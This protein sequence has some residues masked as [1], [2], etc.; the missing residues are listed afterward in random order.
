M[1]PIRSSAAGLGSTV[2]AL[3]VASIAQAHGPAVS[4][5]RVVELQSPAS[6]VAHCQP[7]YAITRSIAT[8]NDFG[9]A[10]GTVTCYRNAVADPVSY[11]YVSRLV[12]GAPW[13]G[14]VELATSEP[15]QAFAYNITNRGEAF[16]YEIPASGGFF[17]TRWSLAG[18]RERL[19]FD[20]ACE[21]IQFSSAVDGNGRYTV[22][23]GLRGDPRLPP[24][25]DQLCISTRWLIRDPAGVET[26][27]PL[28]GSP[29]SLNAFNVAVGTSSQSAIRYNVATGDLVVLHAAEG[30][31]AAEA[32]HINDLGEVA[33]RLTTN[34]PG[35]VGNC[36]PGVAV[37]WD[38]KGLEQVLPH[39][40]G[41]VSS[42]AY[43][44]GYD[45]ET[46]GDSGAGDYC[47]AGDNSGERAVLWKDGR[48]HDLNSLIPKSERITLT[49]A[50]SINRRGQITAGGYANGEPLA[51]CALNVIDPET[52]LLTIEWGLC[53]NTRMYVLTPVG[54][55]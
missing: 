51:T 1:I 45:G 29:S 9:V 52:G 39:L 30:D 35:G 2:A 12:A 48:V 54:N 24:P 15:G 34:G 38:R 32:S 18:G 31:H 16:G 11:E 47:T 25:V 8:I 26:L 49:Y 19:F 28:Y 23:W 13:F 6:L 3:A 46:V 55:H 5:Y 22:G 33:G 17:G 43:A 42:H 41:A 50:Y 36:A 44:V 21:N 27:G 7:G 14:S 53:H 40:P 10:T 4:R 20:P 37:R